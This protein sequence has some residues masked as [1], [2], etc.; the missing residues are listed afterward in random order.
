MRTASE[1]ATEERDFWVGLA[2]HWNRDTSAELWSDRRPSEKAVVIFHDPRED[3]NRR[4]TRW[5][6]QLPGTDLASIALF[7]AGLAAAEAD[8][9]DRDIGD[10]AT[11][12]YEDRRFL[13][14]D[15][16]IHWAIPWLDTVGRCYSAYEALAHGDRNDLLH[17]AEEMR[18]APALAGQEG[19]SLEGE[20][21]YGPVEMTPGP[22][23]LRSLWSGALILDPTAPSTG[24]TLGPDLRLIYDSSGMRWSGFAT[25]YEGSAR[26]WLDLAD[27][28]RRTVAAIDSGRLIPLSGS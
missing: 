21:S 17:L 11:R 10:I 28:A 19:L 4:A 7:A 1:R 5:N 16:L 27:R 3:L 8:S 13:V 24:E 26:L 9:W 23:W 15:R 22:Q 18:V 2:Q 14:G 12:A 25:R 20:D 6:H